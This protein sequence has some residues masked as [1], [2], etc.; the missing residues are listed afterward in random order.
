VPGRVPPS[1]IEIGPEDNAAVVLDDGGEE[2]PLVLVEGGTKI[3]FEVG[4]VVAEE[5]AEAEAEGIEHV[6]PGGQAVMVITLVV[7]T[8]VVDPVTMGNGSTVG[9]CDG[10]PEKLGPGRGVAKTVP[11]GD[12]TSNAE[13]CTPPS[14]EAS[15][16]LVTVEYSVHSPVDEPNPWF[17]V[18]AIQAPEPFA[19]L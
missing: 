16:R 2:T 6:T 14:S 9:G 17:N 5:V 10:C 15:S 3:I 11:F 12:L 1:E 18:I 19:R 13:S 8:M 4:M 7:S